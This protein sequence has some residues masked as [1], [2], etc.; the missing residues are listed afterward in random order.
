MLTVWQHLL[1]RVTASAGVAR[2]PTPGDLAALTTKY[3]KHREAIV[4]VLVRHD[5]TAAERIEIT[6]EV[7]RARA[8]NL[9]P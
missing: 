5:S 9:M 6:R 4:R 2:F 8:V 7:K 1:D 3:P